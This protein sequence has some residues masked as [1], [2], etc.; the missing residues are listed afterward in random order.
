MITVAEARERI[1]RALAPVGAETV[2]VAEAAGRVLAAPVAARL[3]QPPADVSAMDGYALRAAE[4]PLGAV[5]PLAGESAAGRPFGGVLPAGA[6]LRI[7]TGAVVPAGAD[8]ILLQEDAG[9]AGDAVTVNEAPRPGRWIRRRGLDFA[10]GEALLPPGRRLTP[11]EAGLAAAAGHPW[12]SVHRRPRVAILATGDEV[13]LPGDPL[14]AG[15]I[16]SSNAFVLAALVRAA[17]GEAT[18]LPVAPDEPDALLAV[19]RGARGADLLLTSGGASVGDHDQ[20]VPALA[21]A[22]F[23]LDFWKIA[24]RPGKPLVFGDWDGLPV[25]GLPGNPVSA[26]VC[27]V[28][29]ALPALARLG[30][31]AEAAPPLVTARLAAPLPANDHRADHLRATLHRDGAAWRVT[32]APMQDSSMLRILA[33]SDA[34]ILRAPHAPALPPGAEVDCLDL[35]A[36]RA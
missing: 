5:L 10:E 17:G 33:A 23:R 16:V 15:G 1:L 12:L 7:S 36:L 13:A 30:G 24:M 26:F 29:F 18:L 19:A 35:Q 3:T 8:A 21:R 2:S 32:P 22:G 31:L 11:R 25:L 28:V 4:A 9:R 34:L 14:A 6:C 20:T 27:A